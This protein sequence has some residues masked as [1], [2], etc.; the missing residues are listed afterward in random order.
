MVTAPWSEPTWRPGF[1][2]SFWRGACRI[3]GAS[4]GAG[5]SDRRLGVGGTQ[6]SRCLGAPVAC[7]SPLRRYRDPTKLRMAK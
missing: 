2:V 4:S 6:G 5:T 3:S 1:G 7:Y